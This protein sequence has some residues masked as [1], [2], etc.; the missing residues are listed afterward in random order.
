MPVKEDQLVAKPPHL[1]LEAL[2]LKQLLN[3]NKNT[4]N[5]IRLIKKGYS[6]RIAR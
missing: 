6:S 2:F 4:F 1:R 5:K 3:F